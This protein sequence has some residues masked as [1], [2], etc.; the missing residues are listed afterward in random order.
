MVISVH[1][2]PELVSAFE[3]WQA[4]M[5]TAASR[6]KGFQDADVVAPMPEV[7]DEYVVIYRFD[8]A[9][10]LNAWLES[11]DRERLLTQGEHLFIEPEVAHAMSGGGIVDEGVTLVIP[12]R[13]KPGCEGEF[14]R[15]EQQLLEAERRQPGNRGSEL[16]RPV[17][18]AQEEWT[19]LVRFDTQDN[20][21]AWL[22]SPER[23]A[24]VDEIGQYVEEFD[25]RSVGSSFGSWFSFNMVEGRAVPNWKQAMT[26][27]LTLYPTVMILLMTQA[28]EFSKVPLYLAT[29]VSNAVSVSALTWLLMPIATRGLR[30]WLSPTASV[31]ASV[32][33]VALVMALYGVEIF[34]FWLIRGGG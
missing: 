27:L 31:R 4:K 23:L 28:A 19:V 21:D 16:L 32:A 25:V 14:L 17:P 20:A 9:G 33:G 34:I 3:L 18:G 15:V 30:T 5:N 2:R 13:V 24:L 12:H 8:T 22:H 1:V 29:F 10:H 26:V 6:F 11:E 7:Q